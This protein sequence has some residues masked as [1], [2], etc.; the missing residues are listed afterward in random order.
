MKNIGLITL[1]DY[2]FGSALQCYATK[3]YISENYCDVSVIDQKA[4][5]NKAASLFRLLRTAAYAC[6][7]SPNSIRKAFLQIKSQRGSSLTLTEESL[8]R[9]KQFNSDY[10]RPEFYSCRELNEISRSDSFSYFFSGSDQVWNGSRVEKNDYFFLRFAPEDKRVA[11][12]PSFGGDTVE[13][14]NQGLYRQ[15]I[16]EYAFLS[17]REAKGAQII[18]QYTGREAEVL[19][20]PVILLSADEWRKDYLKNSDL[21]LGEPYMLLFF[22]D[23]ISESA[24]ERVIAYQ[25]KTNCRV[26][27]FGYKYNQFNT[28]N[29]YSH[30]DGGPFDFLK[31]IDC[32]ELVVTDSFHATAFSAIFHTPFCVYKRN[33]THNQNQSVRITSFLNNI[34]MLQKFELNELIIEKNT[35]FFE[36]DSFF[37]EQ[38]E[39][40]DRFLKDVLQIPKMAKAD[41]AQ[42]SLFKKES[43][44]CGCGACANV[45]RQNAIK[46]VNN[47]LGAVYPVLDDEKCVHCNACSRVCF[48]KTPIAE[49]SNCDRKAYIGY[50]KDEELAH[51]SASGGI[52]GTLANMVLQKNGVICGAGMTHDANGNIDCQH[53]M[54]YGF[55]SLRRVQNSKYVQSSTECIFPQ[56]KKELV[57]GKLVLFSGTSCQVAALYAFLGKKYEN[58]V[59]IDLICHGVPGV[60]FLRDYIQYY[61]KKENCKVIDLAFRSK[62]LHN[63]GT[64]PYVLTFT[65]A[66]HDG[67]AKEKR[68]PLR[69]SAYYRMFMARSGYREMCYNCQFASIEKPADIT[70]GDYYVDGKWFE[71]MH[72]PFDEEKKRSYSCI[73][74]NTTKGKQFLNECSWIELNEVPVEN[75][76]LEHEQ[77]Q[78]PSKPTAMG[79]KLWNLYEKGGFEKVQR[80]INMRNLIT[81][82]PGKIKQILN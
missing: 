79:K 71:K 69:K 80:Y 30:I 35:C 46:M 25:E 36:A 19:C 42:V 59:T 70:L 4:P 7:K 48:M 1:H 53:M 11:W 13:A 23:C 73:I 27:S 65:L 62:D 16:S 34:K 43:D 8:R 32:A 82:I 50:G 56:V 18:Q 76:I 64:N 67:N 37:D 20:D 54:V 24:L 6:V 57:E 3:K 9:I 52:F 72:I 2:N 39:K 60:G 66:D 78:H 29:H 61:E 40:S 55:D 47:E 15:F 58:L 75:V 44:C 14:Y 68:I 49:E 10:I 45:C 77:L 63:K 28:I 31:I 26:L 33:Y 81:E 17:A 38:K 74:A 21:D 22:I 51:F 41:L 5:K 12:A